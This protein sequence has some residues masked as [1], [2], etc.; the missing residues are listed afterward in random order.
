MVSYISNAFRIFDLATGEESPKFE[1]QHGQIR[2]VA[3]NH[4][5][6][7]AASFDGHGSFVVWD[8]AQQKPIYRKESYPVVPKAM[9]L[10]TQ[11]DQLAYGWGSITLVDLEEPEAE[12]KLEVSRDCQVLVYDPTGKFLAAADRIDN[13]A[14]VSVV[15]VATGDKVHMLKTPANINSITWSA[16]GK[17]LVTGEVSGE[18]R[19][20]KLGATEPLRTMKSSEKGGIHKL[21]LHPGGKGLLVVGGSSYG[22]PGKLGLWNAAT[23]ARLENYKLDGFKHNV[24]GIKASQAQFSHDGRLLVVSEFRCFLFDLS[25]RKL[26]LRLGDP[27][28]GVSSADLSG[29][30]K[31]LITS[32]S[33]E[34]L[35][36]WD[37][38]AT[39]AQ[40]KNDQP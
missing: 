39:I 3:A 17:Q 18:I 22:L 28:N 15:D 4:D 33:A 12:R 35:L 14:C 1:T 7:R 20:W 40:G 21:A 25:Q 30:G 32:S 16:D 36:V 2:D 9:A 27:S 6:S 8:V 37:L 10:S 11:G 38:N 29:D 23:G 19:I 13:Q 34:H 31:R 24:G 5:G 26:I